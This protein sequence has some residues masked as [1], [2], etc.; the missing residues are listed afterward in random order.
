LITIS[1]FTSLMNSNKNS[2]F[3]T[4]VLHID[5]ESVQ[6]TILLFELLN[7]KIYLFTLF[8]SNPAVA[9]IL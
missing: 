9:L 1:T 7:K 2:Q 8:A 4:S 5:R 6:L 3:V